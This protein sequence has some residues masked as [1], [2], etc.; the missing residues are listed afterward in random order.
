MKNK[1]RDLS[2]Y[3][4]MLAF[5]VVALGSIV[6][7]V[8][9]ELFDY[10]IKYGSTVLLVVVIFGTLMAVLNVITDKD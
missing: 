7:L 10:D 8:A 4:G 3:G 1:L 6:A 2:L 5:V 9:K